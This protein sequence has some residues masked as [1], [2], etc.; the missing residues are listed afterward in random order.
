MLPSYEGDSAVTSLTWLSGVIKNDCVLSV[1]GSQIKY[2][3]ITSLLALTIILYKY[4]TPREKRKYVLWEGIQAELQLS[5][6]VAVS[7]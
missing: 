5:L 4:G 2:S 6:G 1:I 3:L 7:N